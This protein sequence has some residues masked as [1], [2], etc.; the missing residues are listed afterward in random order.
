[1]VSEITTGDNSKSTD[2]RERS[3][4][5]AAQ[6]V[7]TIA[8]ANELAFQAARQMNVAGEGV[9]GLGITVANVAVSFGPAGIMIAVAS[10]PV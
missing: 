5:G 8:V 9:P 6:G 2:G 4:F 3:R 1:M 10:M 7:L